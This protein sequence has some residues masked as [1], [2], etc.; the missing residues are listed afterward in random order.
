MSRTFTNLIVGLV[1]LAAY[2]TAR[3]A[4]T[5]ITI[6]G[7]ASPVNAVGTIAISFVDSANTLYRESITYGPG[8]TPVTIASGLGALFTRDY[9]CVPPHSPHHCTGLGSQGSAGSGGTGVVTF[10][11]LGSTTFGP[12]NIGPPAPGS[13]ITVTA[14]NWPSVPTVLQLSSTPNPS[15]S[16]SPI[17]LSAAVTPSSATGSVS[18]FDGSVVIAT[19][20]ISNGLASVGV[21]SLTNGN[22]SITAVYSGDLTYL[23]STAAVVKQTVL[24]PTPTVSSL[25]FDPAPGAMAFPG[26]KGLHLLAS[27]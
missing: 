10:R 2:G 8:S 16:G 27:S 5:S 23:P 19:A 9:I 1:L 18:F 22:H 17:Q 14:T 3:A 6:S 21:P 13:P 15:T 26:C 20:S 7:T 12:I 24:V 4:D 25:S 11:L